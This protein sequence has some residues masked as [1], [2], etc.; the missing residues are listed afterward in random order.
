MN[1]TTKGKHYLGTYPKHGGA[2]NLTFELKQGKQGLVFSMQ[3]ERW[4]THKRD[5]DWGGQCCDELVKAFPN[6]KK[7]ARMVEIWKEWHLNDM[8]AGTHEQDAELAKHVYPGYSVEKSH[9]DWACKILKAAGL[10]EVML[11]GKPY[12]YGRAWLFRPLPELIVNE[13]LSW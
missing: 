1:N 9:Y 4:Q 12:C 8:N 3:G 13:I 2:C 6:D 10:Y 11:D 7:A 5:I